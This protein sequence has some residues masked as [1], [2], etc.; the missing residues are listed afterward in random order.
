MRDWLSVLIL[1]RFCQLWGNVEVQTLVQRFRHVASC[2]LASVVKRWFQA[3]ENLDPASVETQQT[4]VSEIFRWSRGI[5]TCSI[6]VDGDGFYLVLMS[7]QIFRY[8][9]ESWSE[10]RS[11]GD[12][13]SLTLGLLL[14]A[15][16]KQQKDQQ[17]DQ[18]KL[19]QQNG[20]TG[21]MGVEPGWT[22]SAHR[23]GLWCRHCKARHQRQ[24]LEMS[25]L[26]LWAEPGQL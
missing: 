6:F 1:T 18:Q 2:R 24:S 14:K 23:E 20:F 9:C 13:K 26:A 17:K 3:M 7:K 8:R 10:W 4:V 5:F 16:S 15:M 21:L 25:P 19:C 11:A 12:E 22:S